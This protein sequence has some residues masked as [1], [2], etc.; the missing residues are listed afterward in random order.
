[1]P[2]A[3]WLAAG[4]LFVA[5]LIVLTALLGLAPY[6]LVAALL[7][8]LLSVVVQRPQ[9]GVLI[10]AAFA[11][12]EG[13]LP[14]VSSSRVL[15][16]WKEGLVAILVGATLLNTRARRNSRRFR[17]VFW[18]DALAGLVLIA[19][20]SAAAGHNS[21]ALFGLK[22]DFFYV[23]VAW[24]VWRC[25][26][27]SLDRDRLV[28]IIMATGAIAAGFGLLQQVLGGSR[29]HALGYPYNTTITFIGGF[30]KSFGTFGGP[31]GLGFYEMFVI[32]FGLSIALEN[33]KSLRNRLF[34]TLLPLYLLGLVLSFTR[35]AIIGLGV[36]LVYLGVRRYS[37][38][39]LFIPLATISI[40]WVPSSFR[41][42]TLS[43]T[44][45]QQRV[46]TWANVPRIIV[47]NPLGAGLGTTGSAIDK[48]QRG[49][50][51]AAGSVQ[52]PSVGVPNSSVTV[53]LS[54]PDN[55]FVQ[56]VAELGVLGLWLACLLFAG[57]FVGLH[58]SSERTRGPTRAFVD[59]ATVTVLAA[60]VSS[61][62]ATYFSLFPMDLFFWLFV[63]VATA[64]ISKD[65]GPAASTDLPLTRTASPAEGL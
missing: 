60:V 50:P 10:L 7:I 12:L 30:L 58:R 59:G 45:A 27:S 4:G 61:A 11:P 2:Q 39:L 47:H 6:V 63:G 48:A 22:L 15:P 28:T 36:G 37:L 9:R 23:L 65:P 46:A 41:G 42:S 53:A 3:R 17:H 25:P 31:H 32:L 40:L 29:L 35:G 13:L 24:S 44:S 8:P 33:R 14:L 62:T 57:I 1:M 52:A 54:L 64:S 43:P 55:F 49:S 56:T 5:A 18:F 34:L 20:I 16:Y 51:F 26:L 38:L 21:Q 19:L